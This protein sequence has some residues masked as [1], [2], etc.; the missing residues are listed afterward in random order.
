M[1]YWTR[2]NLIGIKIKEDRRTQFERLLKKHDRFSNKTFRY[3]LDEAA[4]YTDGLLWFKSG[5]DD[6]YLPDEE[7]LVPAKDAKWYGSDA[8]AKCLKTF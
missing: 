3:F 1:G 5:D 4:L 8:I 2:L 6:E 7:G